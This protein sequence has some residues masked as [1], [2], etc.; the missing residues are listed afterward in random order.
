[1]KL[2]TAM[3]VCGA[4]TSTT[5]LAASLTFD[6]QTVE[7]GYGFSAKGPGFTSGALTYFTKVDDK[8]FQIMSIVKSG[9][10]I[11]INTQVSLQN[12]END[13]LGTPAAFPPGLFGWSSDSKDGEP[14]TYTFTLSAGGKL[15]F[16]K[17]KPYDLIV[18]IDGKEIGSARTNI[19]S[20]WDPVL[21]NKIAFSESSE[22]TVIF[23][24]LDDDE[25][26]NH[27]E[28]VEESIGTRS[29]KQEL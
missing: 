24:P 3:F 8:I 2:A 1:M 6:D 29:D 25:L 17:E 13:N 23:K 21:L 16:E 11:P 26:I 9:V 18:K 19:H 20:N 4:F 27:G 15:Y 28:L 5:L 12:A 22:I 7:T 10:R 14:P